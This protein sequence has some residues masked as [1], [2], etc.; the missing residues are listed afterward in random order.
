MT[1]AVGSTPTTTTTTGTG[2]TSDQTAL[3][4]TQLAQSFDTFLTLLTAQMK[5]QD[6]LSPMDSTAFTQQLV[7]MTGV[8]QQLASNDLLKQL[9]SNTGTNIASAVDL[10]GKQVQASTS[11]SQLSSGQANWQY[12]LGA[13][14]TDVKIEVLDSTGN[15]VAAYAASDTSAGTHSFS[16]DGK[17]IT[18]KQMPDGAYSLRITASDP[19]GQSVSATPFVKG[20]VTGVEQ[21]NGSTVLTINGGQVP[22]STVTSVDAPANSNTTSNNNSA[23]QTPA[24]AA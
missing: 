10:I 1:T 22:L 4:R 5:N 6:P 18:G 2:S 15:T 21:S 13:G 12:S 8:E 9:V 16:W 3:G 23:S 19:S 17:S 11:T 20:I 24:A 14:A 7:E